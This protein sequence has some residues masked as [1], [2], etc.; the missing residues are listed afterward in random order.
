MQQNGNSS[1]RAH[2][3]LARYMDLGDD[4]H[5]P[6]PRSRGQSP[7][8]VLRQTLATGG[9]V[10]TTRG[11]NWHQGY[12]EGGLIDMISHPL[13][14]VGDIVAAPGRILA[15]KNAIH[16]HDQ[17]EKDAATKAKTDEYDAMMEYANSKR[18]HAGGRTGGIPLPHHQGGPAWKTG[19]EAYHQGGGIPLPH[20]EGGFLGHLGNAAEVGQAY[21]NPVGTAI[22][23]VTNLIK[24]PKQTFKD[25]LKAPGRILRGENFMHPNSGYAEGGEVTEGSS[26]HQGGGIPLPHQQGGPAW[27]TGGQ[28]ASG[29]EVDE[30]GWGLDD[31]E[32]QYEQEASQAPQGNWKGAAQ[33][34]KA[35]RAERQA[36]LQEERQPL[37]PQAR[38]RFAALDQ[39]QKEAYKQKMAAA[40]EGYTRWMQSQQQEPEAYPQEEP[41]QQPQY[42]SGYRAGGS[43]MGADPRTWSPY[44]ID[45]T[46]RNPN[47]SSN[48]LQTRRAGG[49]IPLPHEEGGEICSSRRSPGGA[50]SKQRKDQYY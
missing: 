43:L 29:G 18:R 31:E 49:N 22:E 17:A 10:H 2:N 32:P 5:S 26:Y 41:V 16:P 23:G 48:S 37:A 40:K 3:D 42:V 46:L 13:R 20:A 28:Y 24:N 30:P 33:K 9:S 19:G 39:G 27:K 14:T 6:A 7:E 8:G 47:T 11:P 15:G 36:Q 45:G 50:V 4:N 35:M 38:S 34:V 44:N 21:L 25:I 1:Y 12:A